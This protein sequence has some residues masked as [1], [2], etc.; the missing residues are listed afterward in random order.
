MTKITIDKDVPIPEKKSKPRKYPWAD[1]EVGDS[2][3]MPLS[4]KTASA[5]ASYAGVRYG[6]KF[7]CRKTGPN[8]TR[9][10]RIE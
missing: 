5:Q 2:F 1:M 9:I 10:W 3:E 7:T 6:M 8:T 4:T